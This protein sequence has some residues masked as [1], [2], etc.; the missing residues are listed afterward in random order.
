MVTRDDQF[1]YTSLTYD[2]K[3]GNPKGFVKY[4][5]A[6]KEAA[7]EVPRRDLEAVLGTPLIPV[8]PI[9][10][11]VVTITPPM[12]WEL[13]LKHNVRNRP[14]AYTHSARLALDMI[15]D[16]WMLTHQGGGFNA[17]GDLEDIQHRL[18]A[19]ILA[20]KPVQMMMTT[21]L[22]DDLFKTIDL[23]KTRSAGSA[24]ELAGHNGELTL[25][26]QVIT[27]LAIPYDEHNVLFFRDPAQKKRPVGRIELI[28]YASDHPS[29]IE[30]T[31][32]ALDLHTTALA[33]IGDEAAGVFS[34]WKIR[35]AFGQDVADEFM[36]EVADDNH[37]DKHAITHLQRRIAKHKLGK[38]AGKDDA[39]HKNVLKRD[40][41]VWLIAAAFRALRKSQ[42][43][44]RLDPRGDDQFPRF[45][46]STVPEGSASA[47]PP[48]STKST[49]LEPV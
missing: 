37:L 17:K 43:T 4:M 40:Q 47:S 18:V 29:L 15:A 46:D 20:D 23:G 35:E 22:S 14:I 26:S 32:D 13:I 41:I 39:A 6:A 21:N 31:H 45:E 25:L 28:E 44:I 2:L 7:K 34:Y 33:A 48:Q 49:E 5:E 8:G 12:A 42:R 36:E 16:R 24:L 30:A 10:V 9:K 1:K 19:I 38:R 11:A 27:G 3:S